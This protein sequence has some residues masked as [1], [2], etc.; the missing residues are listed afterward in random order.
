[1]L[2][3]LRGIIEPPRCPWI[4]RRRR[5]RALFACN[6]ALLE[7]VRRRIDCA[8]AQMLVPR[9]QKACRSRPKLT[10]SLTVVGSL[11]PHQSETNHLFYLVPGLHLG[12]KAP[13]HSTATTANAASCL[14]V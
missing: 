6:W 4:F 12:R 14:V 3:L 8:R 1:L 9:R 7:S 5:Q 11:S 13:K 2:L 10:A